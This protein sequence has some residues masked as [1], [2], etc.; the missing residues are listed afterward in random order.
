[1][2]IFSLDDK[3]RPEIYLRKNS[4]GIMKLQNSIKNITKTLISDIWKMHDFNYKLPKEPLIAYWDE[5]CIAHPTNSHCKIFD[6]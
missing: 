2:S 5:E 6:E 4:D 3:Q 1:M